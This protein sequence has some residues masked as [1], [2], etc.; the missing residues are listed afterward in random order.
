MDSITL[1]RVTW[2]EGQVTS[3]GPLDTA[4]AAFPDLG[5]RRHARQEWGLVT[6]TGGKERAERLSLADGLVEGDG[7]YGRV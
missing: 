2:P 4:R 1:E 6:V 7:S 3:K 5:A